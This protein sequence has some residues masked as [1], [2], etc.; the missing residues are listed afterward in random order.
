MLITTAYLNLWNQNVENTVKTTNYINFNEKAVV[1]GHHYEKKAFSH[2]TDI[3]STIYLI[4]L[5]LLLANNVS[6]IY[7]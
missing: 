7:N 4:L 3:Y 5:L 6:F 1:S 2:H